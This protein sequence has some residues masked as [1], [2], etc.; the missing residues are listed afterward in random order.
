MLFFLSEN[1]EEKNL[2]L[3]KTGCALK[4]CG[5]VKQVV[6]TLLKNVTFKTAHSKHYV[7]QVL[8]MEF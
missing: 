8:E 1:D 7:V 5:F 4:I 6:I 3:W 2:V